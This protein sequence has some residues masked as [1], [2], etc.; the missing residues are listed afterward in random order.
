MTEPCR[1]A[2][3]PDPA[4]THET[5]TKKK[6]KGRKWSHITVHATPNFHHEYKLFAL[7][8]GLTMQQ[9]MMESF[10]LF[11]A[12]REGETRNPE[13]D[14]GLLGLEKSRQFW[15]DLSEG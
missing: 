13:R 2:S 14:G 9:L 4:A 5:V 10:E 12:H 8:H 7:T 3:D 1:T 15:R 11:K 6:A